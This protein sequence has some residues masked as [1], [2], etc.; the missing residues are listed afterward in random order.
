[1]IEKNNAIRNERLLYLINTC[2]PTIKNKSA[3][4]RLLYDKFGEMLGFSEKSKFNKKYNYTAPDNYFY[5]K[6]L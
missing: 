4:A 2:T 6:A 5:K 1:M 3:F